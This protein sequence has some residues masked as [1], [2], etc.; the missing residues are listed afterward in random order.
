MS[1][2]TDLFNE[3]KAIIGMVHLLP[4][5]GSSHF[6]GD[7]D[8]VYEQAIFDTKALEEGGVSALMVENFG[9]MPYGKELS[10]EQSTALAAA[11]AVVKHNTKLPIGIDAAFCDYKAA[12]SCAKA[13]GA[14]FIRLAVFVDTVECFAGIL[15]P[16]A[17]KALEYR[18]KIQ[19]QDIMIFADIQ[20]KH[21]HMVIPNVPIEESA[22]VA[23]SCGAD[24]II[25]TG[26][27]TGCETPIDVVKKVK[28]S[29]K[30]PVIVGSGA[31][32][33]NIKEQMKIADGAIVGSS[34]KI[35][36]KVENKVDIDRVKELINNLI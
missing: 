10:L 9:D 15:E 21:T 34:L 24:A 13:S 1:K 26:S 2:F 18:K 6:D 14:D 3:N 12:L 22:A 17:S 19:A 4:L 8:K 28:N 35:D 11:A 32:A 5:P 30:C 23:V 36:G 7:M 20:V 29:V 31:K 33:S 25:V 16:C 27:A